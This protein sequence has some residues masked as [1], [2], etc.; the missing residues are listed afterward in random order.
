MGAVILWKR[1]CGV[2]SFVLVGM[3]AS[4][5]WSPATLAQEEREDREAWERVWSVSHPGRPKLGVYLGD[6]LPGE[7]GG[8]VVNRVSHGGPAEEAGIREGDVIVS[9]AGHLLSDPLDDETEWGNREWSPERRLRALMDEVEEG[10][11]VEVGVDRNGESLTFTVLPERMVVPAVFARP[12]LDT[13]S[14][15]LRGMNERVREM[16]DE[17]RDRYEEAEWP[18][19]VPRGDSEIVVAPRLLSEAAHEW[20]VGFQLFGTHSLDLVELNPELGAYFG[21]A[22]G[23]LVADADK[24][25]PLGLRP[26]DV[27]VAVEGRKVDDVA[28]LRRILGSYT[29]DEDIEF[30][31]W[32]DGAETMIVGTI[33]EH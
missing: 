29:P 28:E 18:H 11:E 25:S 31:V 13:L 22:E 12:T 2:A 17:I 6:N 21:T 14:I 24:E 33:S 8:V 27:V 7:G 5:V 4:L 1:G 26:G 15:H 10:D 19:L 16:M 30:R 32:R 3:L 20:R 9:I 23:V